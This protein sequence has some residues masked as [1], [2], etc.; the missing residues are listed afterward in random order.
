MEFGIFWLHWNVIASEQKMQINCSVFEWIRMFFFALH[1]QFSLILYWKSQLRPWL[2]NVGH[3]AIV[4]FYFG[5][6][7]HLQFPATKFLLKE[8]NEQLSEQPLFCFLYFFRRGVVSVIVVVVSLSL[9]HCFFSWELWE[10]AQP[11][12]NV[13]VAMTLFI[14]HLTKLL[15]SILAQT[16]LSLTL[17]LI[18][19]QINPIFFGWTHILNWWWRSFCHCGLVL[20]GCILMIF[21]WDAPERCENE[22][23]TLS[24]PIAENVC[25]VRMLVR[26]RQRPL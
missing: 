6:F 14:S 22:C 19:Q 17:S 16:T 11:S 9:S 2:P 5:T 10:R 1:S 15:P 4:R 20:F 25:V 7:L 18:R 8:Q 26:R 3:K 21:A 23:T 12:Q 13:N 24:Y